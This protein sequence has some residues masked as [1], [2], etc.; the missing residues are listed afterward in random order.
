M[1][2]QRRCA[3]IGLAPDES[4]ALA[5]AEAPLRAPSVRRVAADSDIASDLL[6]V[7]PHRQVLS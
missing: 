3:R 5:L 4:L 1:M 2:S 6:D 7:R